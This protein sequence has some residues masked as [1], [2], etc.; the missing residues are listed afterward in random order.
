[1]AAFASKKL[2]FLHNS[3]KYIA[4][5]F[6]K[7]LNHVKNNATKAHKPDYRFSIIIDFRKYLDER[8]TNLQIIFKNFKNLTILITSK[9]NFK[10]CF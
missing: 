3:S 8:F 4:Q 2:P 6:Q 10:N 9:H 1:M 5:I 7:F